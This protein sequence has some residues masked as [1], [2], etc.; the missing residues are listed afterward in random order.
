MPIVTSRFVRIRQALRRKVCRQV[1]PLFTDAR[2]DEVFGVRPLR[3]RFS[4]KFEV[5]DRAAELH[6][7]SCAGQAPAWRLAEYTA[8]Y[9]LA[10][11]LLKGYFK[12]MPKDREHP[13]AW[14]DIADD[15]RS[16]S[17]LE[18]SPL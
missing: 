12:E 13:L 15:M 14:A 16:L 5:K 2:G 4:D 1:A 10:E 7:V 3:F 11:T 8:A 17:Q 6:A 9:E 18:G